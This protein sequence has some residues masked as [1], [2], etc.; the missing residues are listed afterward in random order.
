MN[1]TKTL[2]ALF[3][4]ALLSSK[5]IAADKPNIIFILADDMGYGDLKA[6]NADCRN[7]APAIDRIAAA[8]MVF[9]DMHTP[10]AWCVPSRYGLMTASYPHRNRRNWQKEPVITDDELTVPKMLK[11]HGY[12]TA[13]VGKWHLG[14]ESGM[15][16]NADVYHGGPVDRGFDSFYGLPHS[17]DIQPYLY[18]VNDKAE[19]K[20]TAKVGARGPGKA[21]WNNI[22]G[23]FWRAGNASPGFDHRK[24]LDILA[25]KSVATI[26]AHTQNG[27]KPLFLYVP[28]T[29]PHT[30]WLPADRFLS[31]TPDNMYAAFVAHVDDCVRRIDQAIAD[32]GMTDNTILII[33]SDNG[34]VWYDKDKKRTGHSAT[35]VL[36]GMKGDVWEGGHRVPFVVR[37]PGKVKAG[38]SS[39]ELASFVDMLPTF[40]DIVGDDKNAGKY[41]DG[42]SLKDALMGGK[43]K[44]ETLV[45]LG[46]GRFMALRSKNWKY[47]PFEGSGGFSKP[48]FVRPKEGEKRGQLYDLSKDRAEENNLYDVNPE[49][50]TQFDAALK[51]AL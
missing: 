51:A 26:R 24:V 48:R 21:H 8:G 11:A 2:F 7:L 12:S 14:F 45:H 23:E 30:P 17:L 40:A 47:I 15:N 38:S 29:A 22:Q 4:F 42:Y 35:A 1:A 16:F 27:N 18:I 32:N 5:S 9:T 3:L 33:T 10:A 13:M 36:R 41:R 20:P 39:A 44:R 31:K 19:A 6:T 50:V 46:T 25:D 43:T 49:L 28:L 34:P 37:W